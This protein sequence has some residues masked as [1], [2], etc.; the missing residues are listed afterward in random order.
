MK[1]TLQIKIKVL[2]FTKPKMFGIAFGTGQEQRWEHDHEI[3]SR[4]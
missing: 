3:V 2:S 4:S 1:R